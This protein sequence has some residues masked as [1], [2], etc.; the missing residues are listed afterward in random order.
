MKKALFAVAAALALVGPAMAEP[1][2]D[3]KDLEAIHTQ[4]QQAIQ[5][6]DRVRKAN[7]YDM[8]DHGLKA[9]AA[10]KNAERELNEAISAA[11]AAK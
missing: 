6:L 2:K 1:V 3:T 11:K 10:L 4:I 5:E 8:S 9:E 7:N